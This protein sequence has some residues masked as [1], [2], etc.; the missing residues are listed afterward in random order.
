VAVANL[1]HSASMPCGACRQ[2]ILE[3]A[4]PGAYVFYPG[5][6]DEAAEATIAELL[7]AA[8][9]FEHLAPGE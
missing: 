3:F 2:T 4:D 6:H 9:S 8:F 5:A 7:P 1:N